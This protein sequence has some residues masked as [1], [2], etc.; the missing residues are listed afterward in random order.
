MNAKMIM[1]IGCASVAL[2]AW[3]QGAVSLAPAAGGG[4]AEAMQGQ[5]AADGELVTVQGRGV[6]ATKEA[7]LKDAYRDAIERAVGLYVDAE[8]VVKN[9]EQVND[10]ILTQ[11]NAY[12]KKYDVVKESE[13][14]GLFTVR[15][16]ATVKKSALTKKLGDVMPKQSFNLGTDAAN[17]HAQI[18]TREKRNVDAVALLENVLKGVNPVKQMMTFSLAETKMIPRKTESGK[19][20]CYYHFKMVI[21]AKKYFEEFLPPLM[22]V[23]DQ[24]AIE[25]P[26]VARFKNVTPSAMNEHFIRLTIETTVRYLSGDWNEHTMADANGRRKRNYAL[27]I[28]DSG[29]LRNSCSLNENDGG[30]FTGVSILADAQDNKWCFSFHGVSGMS[31]KHYYSNTYEG[32]SVF[33]VVVVTKANSG[34]TN[35]QAKRYMLPLSCAKVVMDWERTFVGENHKSNTTVY[36][37]I[38]KAKDGEEVYSLPVSLENM[39]LSNTLLGSSRALF[40]QDSQG[41]DCDGWYVTPFLHADAWEYHRWIGFEIPRDDL[42]KIASIEIELAE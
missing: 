30:V 24:I 6:G 3:S 9:D 17:L 33:P 12:I 26:K 39:S 20:A 1:S 35:V 31:R 10:Q 25:P 34:K 27:S 11:S 18:V 29:R 37:I 22:K 23:L 21:D 2:G 8:Q 16:L 4:T 40:M 36:N 5:N 14:D 7:A 32:C 28:D 42:P 38:F 13:V 41:R 19:G 15:I